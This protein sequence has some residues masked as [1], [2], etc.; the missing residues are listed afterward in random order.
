[1]ILSPLGHIEV[2]YHDI[3]RL[4]YQQILRLYVSVY[5]LFGV[6]VPNSL[7][8]LLKYFFCLVLSVMPVL[9]QGNVVED[10]YSFNIVHDLMCFTSDF[11]LEEIVGSDHVGMIKFFGKFVFIQNGHFLLWIVVARNLNRKTLLSVIGFVI[12]FTYTLEDR[13]MI[14]LAQL[15]EKVVLCFK[16]IIRRFYMLKY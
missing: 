2:Y 14:A 1:M 15:L 6:E 11:V 7:D 5:H 9:L 10:F 8:N 4:S 13:G 16:R 12:R 3:I